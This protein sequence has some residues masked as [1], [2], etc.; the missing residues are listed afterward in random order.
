MTDDSILKA[1]E[2]YGDVV[3]LMSG[4]RAKFIDAGWSPHNAEVA[5]IT[6]F[7]NITNANR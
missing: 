5:V 2:A 6:L 1:L 7:A 3:G 4:V